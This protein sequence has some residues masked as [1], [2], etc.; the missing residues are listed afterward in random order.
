MGLPIGQSI[1]VFK[2]MWL[3]RVNHTSPNALYERGHFEHTA[4]NGYFN[5]AQ[6]GFPVIDP[7]QRLS[8]SD[9][10]GHCTL[11]KVAGIEELRKESDRQ[12]GQVNSDDQVAFKLAR[13]QRRMNAPQRTRLRES[14][15]DDGKV[16][17]LITNCGP[18]NSS[19]AAGRFGDKIRHILELWKTIPAQEQRLVAAHPAT[20]SSGQYKPA[21]LAHGRMV[22]VTFFEMH[23]GVY[24]KR[25]NILR[26]SC[27]I[28]ALALMGSVYSQTAPPASST[29]RT[30]ST[31][32]A[33]YRTGRLVRTTVVVEPRIVEPKP[34]A[35]KTVE[36]PVVPALP[37]NAPINDIVEAAASKHGVDPALVHS[38][39]KAESN[40]NPQA[41][42][43]AG[44]RGLMQ[45]MPATARQLGVHNSFN[46]K[47]NIEGG[48]KHLKYLQEK[49]QD[50][51]LALA[52]YNAGEG[53]V[54]KYHN[55]VPPYRE[56]QEY[57]V[58]VAKNYRAAK[59]AARQQQTQK[60]E[61]ATAAVASPQAEPEQAK[62]P[63]YRKV[64]AYYD[65]NGR[66]F[67]RTQQQ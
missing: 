29:K 45:L 52:A 11:L 28:T 16:E 32:K 7:A 4:S 51:V 65:A 48:V 56:T 14:I 30:V 27:W 1:H 13:S 21:N 61:V 59:A 63:E 66:L 67:L 50:P 34:I 24:S 57:V 22:P 43:I 54:A 33:D 37:E 46:P 2:Q 42:S 19:R 5:R 25:R 60:T 12:I 6:A 20:V 64:E 58:K 55:N 15:F 49:F 17:M 40:Y 8:P 23:S 38:V 36:N 10:A 18:N 53:A 39:I 35:A 47:D 9:H 41:V 26:S 3:W 31:V 44:A 62:A